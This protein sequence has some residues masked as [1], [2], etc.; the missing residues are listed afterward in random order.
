MH[1]KED[2]KYETCSNCNELVLTHRVCKCGYYKCKK[3]TGGWN[4][5]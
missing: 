2:K 5:K 3:I 1:K 4:I